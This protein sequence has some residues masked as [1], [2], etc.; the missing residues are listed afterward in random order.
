MSHSG[1]GDLHG[2]DFRA[3]DGHADRNP[4]RP[5]AG[6]PVDRGR[7]SRHRDR[8]VF[9]DARGFSRRCHGTQFIVAQPL[10]RF[11]VF[12]AATIIHAAAFV[13]ITP[14]WGCGIPGRPTSAFSSRPWPMRWSESSPSSWRSFCRALSSVAAWRG[15]SPGASS[16]VLRSRGPQFLKS[17]RV[18]RLSMP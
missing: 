2:A 17:L 1:R 7:C 9:D 11:V 6:R 5:G 18:A 4:C 16:E 8:R 3:R 12:L 15:S 14:S 13:G 10:S